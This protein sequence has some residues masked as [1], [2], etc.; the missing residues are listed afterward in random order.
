MIERFE[1]VADASP[2]SELLDK[3]F[4]G[5]AGKLWAALAAIANGRPLYG[6]NDT[7]AQYW[8]KTEAYFKD[9]SKEIEI[10][11][12]KLQTFIKPVTSSNK[13]IAKDEWLSKLYNLYGKRREKLGLAVFVGY[14]ADYKKQKRQF[15]AQ[16]TQSGQFSKQARE[17]VEAFT[18]QAR[19]LDVPYTALYNEL[20]NYRPTTPV[21]LYRGLQYGTKIKPVKVGQKI[22]IT[23]KY[24]SSWTY[25]AE[26]ADRFARY[27]ASESL[28]MGMLMFFD[29][30][31]EKKDYQGKGGFVVTAMV[32]P[33]EMLV[34]LTKT[35]SF[36]SGHGSESEV[37]VLPKKAIEAK[38]I[39]VIG[40]K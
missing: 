39:K 17:F 2:M 3:M 21:K 20:R 26:T 31:K 34:D 16:Y 5:P 36:F 28:G 37:I 11:W 29:Q 18:K 23:G 19:Y 38:V 8:K 33:E 9:K 7:S 13:L 22:K 32:D 30:L 12:E 14:A 35:P 25:S 27:Q 40:G 10:T 15:T 6:E 1:V 24:L 4:T